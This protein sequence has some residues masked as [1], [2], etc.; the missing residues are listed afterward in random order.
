M[1]LF[2][3][4]TSNWGVMVKVEQKTSLKQLDAACD[5][6]YL[7]E[8]AVHF[9]RFVVRRDLEAS[10]VLLVAAALLVQAGRD[11]DVCLNLLDWERKN[12]FPAGEN[13]FDDFPP[14]S[15]LRRQ[16]L[17]SPLV[18]EPGYNCPMIIDGADRLYL[19]RY[20]QY[21]DSL[22]T[23]L[24]QRAKIV[25][26][27]LDRQRL[28]G[29]LS[30]LFPETANHREID[31]Q[32]LAAAIACLKR[33]TVI[34]GGPGTGKTFTVV[35][36]LAL[37]Q[38]LASPDILRV[39]L[40]APTGKAAGRLQQSIVNAGNELIAGGIV[41]PEL[42][43]EAMTIHRLLGSRPNSPYF[44]HNR[45]N[46]LPI[47]LLVVDEASMIDLALMS[48]LVDSLPITSRLVLLGDR[49]QLASVEAGRVLADICGLAQANEFTLDFMNQ[50]A[51]LGFQGLTGSFQSDSSALVDCT[52]VL[53][54]T[55]RF[56]SESGI[57]AI[58]QAVKSQDTGRIND[59]L[60]SQKFDDVELIDNP[61]EVMADKLTAEVCRG[62]RDYLQEQD[63]A[64]AFAAFDRFRVLTAHRQGSDGV[65]K[66]NS[67]LVD[68][69]TTSGLI[70]G[71]DLWYQGRPVMVTR[72]NYNLDLY[73]GDVG[74][75]MAGPDG[76]LRVCFAGQDGTFRY[77]PVFRMP[78]HETAF[79]MTVHKSQGSEYDR[80]ILLLP[81]EMSPVLSRELIYTAVT[82]ARVSFQVWG[83][84]E[85]LN[86][87]VASVVR[88]RSG[89][90]DR[91]WL[92]S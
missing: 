5:Q 7:T 51:G 9:A 15:Q 74:L 21:E 89:L 47:D 86:E 44:R 69:L 30:R 20:W 14:I 84:R 88:R 91:L 90:H 36:L 53:Q 52:V 3:V 87:A 11:G 32:C 42:P 78:E 67:W 65:D 92:T 77:L 41:L 17:Q 40:V 70:K 38:E 55:Y 33:F 46:L 39:A 23:S 80:V 75:T 8:L 22:A 35:K 43:Q 27:D 6:G 12:P 2:I 81:A 72:N 71:D 85:V 60:T 56:R 37:L 73:N 24:N 19:H 68:Q 25:D 76:D 49:D 26:N 29:E 10:P 63:P 31:W 45:Q 62:Y 13:I 48:K 4:L 50:L 18:G 66:L 64:A 16:L 57:A 83:S 34:S 28:Q 82:R 59:C 58:A 79:V 1:R 54:K 61:P